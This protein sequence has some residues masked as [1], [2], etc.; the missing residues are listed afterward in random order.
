M[1]R[2]AKLRKWGAFGHI[3]NPQNDSNDS[4]LK[5]CWDNWLDGGGEKRLSSSNQLYCWHPRL[6]LRVRYNESLLPPLLCQVKRKKWIGDLTLIELEKCNETIGWMVAV[7][8]VHRH[9]INCISMSAHLT[10]FKDQWNVAAK[11]DRSQEMDEWP[12]TGSSPIVKWDEWLDGRRAK[13]PLL[14]NQ[15]C[16]WQPACKAPAFSFQPSGD[17]T[18][19]PS[20]L[21]RISLHPVC[22]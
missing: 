18:F 13:C 22:M 2:I 11:T 19:G 9:S 7:R 12:H 21:I 17:E 20:L 5:V 8:S 16:S 14:S 10:L 4:R 6:A 15:L 3:L 1:G